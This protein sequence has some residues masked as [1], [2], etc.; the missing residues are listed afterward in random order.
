MEPKPLNVESLP[1][2]PP[3]STCSRT[4]TTS[5]TRPSPPPPTAMP[6]PP[7]PPPPPPLPRK[8]STADVSRSAS[9]L[10]LIP[11]RCHRRRGRRDS[12]HREDGLHRPPRAGSGRS[13]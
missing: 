4:T 7:K 10:Y 3:P 8:S 9:S 13:A 1:L 6:R 5:P 11:K 2:V 12:A